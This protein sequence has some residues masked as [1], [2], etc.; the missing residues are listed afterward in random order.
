MERPRSM[1]RYSA[2]RF[3]GIAAPLQDGS[4]PDATASS[5]SGAGRAGPW[6]TTSA[7]KRTRFMLPRRAFSRFRF[8]EEEMQGRSRAGDGDVAAASEETR[9]W[10][11]CLA[12]QSEKRTRVPESAMAVAAR[13]RP[14]W[15]PPSAE[16]AA[17]EDDDDDDMAQ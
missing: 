15:E 8:S 10:S 13:A 7:A 17:A 9:W 14:A 12:R 1:P 11:V 2:S 3:A 6:S 4:G 16:P 5:T